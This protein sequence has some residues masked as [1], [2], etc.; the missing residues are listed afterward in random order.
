MLKPNINLK[1]KVILVTGTTV[2]IGAISVADYS[3]RVMRL[4]RGSN[5]YHVGGI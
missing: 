3:H 5:I 2:F 1:G 4:S